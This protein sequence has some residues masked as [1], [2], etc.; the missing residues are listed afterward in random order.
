MKT[1]KKTNRDYSLQANKKAKKTVT[2][3]VA[4]FVC[5][6]LCAVPVFAAGDGISDPLKRA[7]DVLFTILRI[8][9]VGIAGWSFA[10]LGI[11]IK[12]HDGAQKATAALGIAGGLIIALSKTLLEFIGIT[13]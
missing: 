3:L 11:A 4:V 8:V 9:G 12:S 1:M 5:L 10:E 13:Y 7:M 6:T 2:C